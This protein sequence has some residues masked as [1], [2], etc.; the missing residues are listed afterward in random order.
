MSAARVSLTA[1]Q[2]SAI[3]FVAAHNNGFATPQHDGSVFIY[4]GAVG[5]RPDGSFYWTY[6][7][8]R[9]ATSA[10]VRG[11]LGY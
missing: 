7:R 8:E 9:A 4:S 11:I 10:D 6:V 5:R 3:R 1:W 2:V